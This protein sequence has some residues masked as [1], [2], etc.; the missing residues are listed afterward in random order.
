MLLALVHSETSVK[1]LDQQFAR[2]LDNDA[3]LLRE[4]IR[5]VMA[6]DVEPASLLLVKLG[7][8]PAQIPPGMFVPT[9]ASWFHLIIWLLKLGTRVPAQALG[10]VGELYTD[11]MS[12]MFG[13]GPL[14]PKLLAWLHAWLVELEEDGS[15]GAPQ[16]TYSGQFGYRE[17]RGLT[18]KLRTGFL[19]FCNKVPDLAVDYLNR[20]RAHEHGRGIVSS[21]MKFRGALAQAAPRELAAL[22]AECLI[23]QREEDDPYRRPELDEP[24]Q[25][26]D[27]EFVPAAPAHGPFLELLTHAPDEGLALIRKL[28]DHAIQFSVR[29]KNPGANGLLIRLD[30]GER[31]FPWTGTYQWPRGESNYYAVGSGLMA[32]EAW[33]HQCI[34]AGDDFEVV[35]KDILGPPGTSAAFVLIAVDLIISH[36]PKSQ[37]AAVP[38]LGCPELL[39]IDRARQGQDQIEYPDLFGLKAWEKEPVGAA[40]RDNLKQRPSRRVP[41]ENLVGTYACFGPE[42]LRARLEA[43]LQAASSVS[44][45]L[46]QSRLLPTRG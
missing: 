39:S 29:G 17:G 8:N 37:V 26:L 2:L 12:G 19:M 18:D 32:L 7:V 30:E 11:W 21:I 25:F 35:L 23:A 40:T 4:L 22:T 1:L 16:R 20:V 10:D 34:E 5:T 6:V 13:H 33:A 28:A 38:F 41:V 45:R 31:F 43:L 9:G 44:A 3:A 24:F 42:E 46:S 14:T 36:W 27:K 15:P